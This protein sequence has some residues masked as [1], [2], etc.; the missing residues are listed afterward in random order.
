LVFAA[1]NQRRARQRS[2]AVCDATLTRSPHHE[3]F[4]TGLRAFFAG[5]SVQRLREHN[6]VARVIF[7][8]ISDTVFATE[9]VELSALL[10]YVI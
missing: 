7:D 8:V 3:A 4:Y 10:D 2:A 6:G 9:S 5:L 1:A